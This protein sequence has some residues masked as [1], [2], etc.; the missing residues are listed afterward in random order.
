MSKVLFAQ[1]YDESWLGVLN[2]RKGASELIVCPAFL[3][4]DQVDDSCIAQSK[5]PALGL[6]LQQI[7]DSFG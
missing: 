5:H 1:V 4:I 2:E 6:R 7:G 3:I